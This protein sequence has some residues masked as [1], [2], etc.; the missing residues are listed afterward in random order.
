MIA[1]GAVGRKVNLLPTV[2]MSSTEAEFM[3]AAVMDRMMLF[4]RSIMWGLGIPQCA[5]T[6]GYEDNDACTLMAMPKKPTPRTRHIVITYHVTCQWTE[7][8]LIQLERVTLALNVA[9]IFTKQLGTLLFR[10]HCDYLMG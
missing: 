4:Y 5:S 3:E 8:D 2:G 6:V 7:Q 9:D 10:R 1:G